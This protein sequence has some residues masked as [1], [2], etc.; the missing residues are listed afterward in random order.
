V[1]LEAYLARDDRIVL[2]LGSTEQ[3]AYLSL[4]TDSILAERV[5]VEAAEPLGVPVLPAL[6][7]GFTPGFGA[8]P[9]SPTLRLDT[10][11]AIVRELLDSLAG[12]GFGRI[13]VVN[14]HGG[15]VPAGAL[16]RE[17]MADNPGRQALFHS[18]WS[19]P[20][21]WAVVEEIDR[22]SSH[23]SWIESFPWT[24][25]EGTE[26]PRERKPLVDSSELAV[27]DPA[28]VRELV[29]DGSYGGLYERPEGD[30]RRV[31][32]AGVAEAREVL[33]SGWRQDAS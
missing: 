6:P 13:L 30:W 17:W 2:P 27:S 3:H 12:Q 21:V 5:S 26:V 24:R 19:A 8:Y 11:L 14:G 28:R 22:D 29:G 10:Y 31:W 25:V 33:E 23:A 9:G 16:T 18:W 32:E 20:K 1:H 7:Y 15:N 4:A